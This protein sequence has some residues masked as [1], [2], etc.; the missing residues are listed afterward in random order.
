[1]NRKTRRRR[2]GTWGWP[3]P[4]NKGIT[5]A[6]NPSTQNTTNSRVDWYFGNSQIDLPTMVGDGD[7]LVLAP[8]QPSNSGGFSNAGVP[9]GRGRIVKIDQTEIQDG[10]WRTADGVLFQKVNRKSETMGVKPPAGAVVLFD[11]TDLSDAMAEFL[12][13]RGL[14][15]DAIALDM[16]P[17][18]TGHPSTIQER[19]Y[20]SPIWYTP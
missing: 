8:I 15:V 9:V 16:N 2:R 3:N 7:L 12:R 1:M 5:T 4:K 13:A 11:G 20:S 18:D 17:K 14:E 10:K 6:R 19:A